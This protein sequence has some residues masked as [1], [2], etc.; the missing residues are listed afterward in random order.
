MIHVFYGNNVTS[1]VYDETSLKPEEKE[2]AILV[3]EKLPE[4]PPV[5][6]NIVNILL[7]DE[8]IKDLVWNQVEVKKPENIS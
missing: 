4:E 8:K 2:K 7:Y 3:L 5:G 6:E 1:I